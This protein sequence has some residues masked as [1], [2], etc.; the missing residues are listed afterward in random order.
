VWITIV[1]VATVGGVI[2]AAVTGL[3]AYLA[4]NVSLTIALLRSVTLAWTDPATLV[5]IFQQIR[6]RHRVARTVMSEYAFDDAMAPSSLS[7]CSPWPQ[8]PA[9]CRGRLFA[10]IDTRT[11]AAVLPSSVDRL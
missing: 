1:V 5:P 4:L 10:L 2:T 8:A 6:I 9:S 11:E 7:E 3:T